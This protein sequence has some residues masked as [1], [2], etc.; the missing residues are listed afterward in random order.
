M[1]NITRS[2]FQAHPFHLVSPSPWPLF[3][4]IS[5][6]TLTTSGVMVLTMHGFSNGGYLFL[7]GLLS[8]IASMAFWFRDVAAE[9]TYLGD[10]TSAVQRGLNLGVALFIASEAL[11]F[12]SVFWAFFHSALSPTVELG[13]QWP[14]LGI[15]AINPFE[16]PLLN[17]VILLSSGITVTYAHHSLIQGNRPGV[18]YGLIATIFLAVVFTACQGI[19]YTVSSFTLSDGSFG[20]CF[21]FGT[22]VII[23]TIF[24]A[25]G[26]W[27]ILAYHST[28]NHHLGFESSILYW[29]A[30]R[31][32]IL[33]LYVSVYYWGS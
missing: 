4:S 5:L 10:H 17:T 8:L 7:L 28:D 30:K 14:P 26:F 32:I 1:T 13:A 12:L 3:T 21:Y 22:G 33:F 15:T 29:H 11:F 25:V 23:G 9:G 31:I 18:L 20:S 27:R 2:N 6:L 19:E 16:L 24:I